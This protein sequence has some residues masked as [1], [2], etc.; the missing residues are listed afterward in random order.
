MSRG[1]R[2][3]RRGR[4]PASSPLVP[5]PSALSTCFEL[6]DHSLCSVNATELFPAVKDRFPQKTQARL[7]EQLVMQNRPLL[8][9][10]AVK[11]QCTYDGERVYLRL[12]SGS[13]VG[14]VPLVSPLSGR[15]DFGMVIQPRFPWIGIGPMLGQMGWRVVPRPLRL[16]LLR[17]SER[18]VPPWVIALMVLDR[19]ESLARQLHRRFELTRGVLPAPKGTVLW[20]EYA[21]RHAALG[22]L[23]EVPCRFPDL[24]DDRILKGMMRWTLETQIASL[25]TQVHHGAFVHQ[26]ID[27]ARTVLAEVQDATPIRPTAS[28]TQAMARLPLR[29]E[30]MR[31]GLEAIE[32]TADERGLAGLCDLEGLP[33]VMDMDAFFEAWLECVLE[34]VVRHTGGTLRRGR[35]R[36]TVFPVRWERPA[37]RTQVSLIPDFVLESPGLTLI[38]DAK[39]KRHLEELASGGWSEV[40]EDVRESHRQDLLQALAYSGLFA[41][42]RLTALLAYPCERKTWAS[43]RRRGHPIQKAAVGAGGRCVDLWLAAVPMAARVEEAAEPLIEAL[44]ELRLQAA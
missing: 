25:A 18:R 26:L 32:W 7:A 10:L 31:E 9:K 11:A 21:T 14:A 6:T 28:L 12:E 38:A 29:S 17:R 35:L 42:P 19:L 22:R 33:W 23:H 40:A 36:Q 3:E 39:Y 8:E 5:V 37:Q 44:R 30:V 24:R 4:A 16:P 15:F 41:S 1:Y 43:L 13:A 20:Q 27:R 2:S 34:R